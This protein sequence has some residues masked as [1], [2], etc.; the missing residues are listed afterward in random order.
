MPEPM[1]SAQRAVSGDEP[2]PAAVEKSATVQEAARP[3]TV[4]LMNAA[5]RIATAA[6]ARAG[7]ETPTLGFTPKDF[8]LFGVPY[9]NPGTPIY[10]RRNGAQ[11]F[12]I[13]SG[14]H[15]VPFG[16]DRLLIIWLATAFKVCGSP[17][18]NAISFD[19]LAAVARALGKDTAGR[20]LN[21]IKLGFLRL[22][23]A[24]FLATDSRPGASQR[25]RYQLMRRMRLANEIAPSRSNQFTMWPNVLLY[26]EVFAADIRADAIPTDLQSVRALGENMG[27]LS[28]YQW[29]AYNSYVHARHNRP[30][31]CVPILGASGLLAQ[32]GCQVAERDTR[33]ARATIR[34]WHGIVKTLWP[35]CPNELVNNDTGMIV[36]AGYAM[37]HGRL[38]RADEFGVRP[39]AP[40]TLEQLGAAGAS[41][42]ERARALPP[43]EP[44]L[45]EG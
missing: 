3:A 25:D 26:D 33:F 2:G 17:E 14:V 36:R 16:Q 6:S 13:T 32:I 45:D 39:L 18:T 12:R 44:Q 27:P 29:E 38:P 4:R 10:T 34:K 19:S 21:R 42:L 31:R 11:T 41:V 43:R 8:V 23:D 5:A 1:V 35:S 15:G 40:A 28:L 37:Q 20:K 30:D 24:T 9:K 22:F 7:E